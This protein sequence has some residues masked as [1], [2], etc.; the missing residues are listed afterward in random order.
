M[1]T[2]E[3]RHEPRIPVSRRGE[4]TYNGTRFP[5]LIH[6]ISNHGIG[7]IC[8]RDPMVGQ[9]LELKFELFPDQHYQCKIKIRHIDNGCMGSE[10]MEAD[11]DA[12]KAYLNFV[13]RHAEDVRNRSE[14]ASKRRTH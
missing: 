7:M 3:L 4:L 5:C 8:A 13:R 11:R 1:N 14:E 12:E 10:I 6:D 9:T 2:R